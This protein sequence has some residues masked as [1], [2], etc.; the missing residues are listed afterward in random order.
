V[1]KGVWKR[2]DEPQYSSLKWTLGNFSALLVIACLTCLGATQ[3]WSLVRYIIAQY[4]KSP[5]LPGDSTPDP[6]L[7]LSQGKAIAAVVPVLSE[8][9]SQLSERIPPLFRSRSGDGRNLR[10][11]DQPVE[12]PLFGIASIVIILFFLFIGV[13]IPWWLTEGAL[14]TPIVKS[15]ITEDCLPV[16]VQ[17]RKCYIRPKTAALN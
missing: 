1:L 2:Y 13:A 7:E 10:S 12:S 6:L 14:G 3:Y 17:G 9:L 8:W 16:E 5:R 11:Q 4:K 15:K